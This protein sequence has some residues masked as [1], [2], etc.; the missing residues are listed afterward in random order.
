MTYGQPLRD[1]LQAPSLAG[2]VVLAGGAGLD[3]LVAGLNVMEVP[4]I[5]AYVKADELLLTT[6]F[7]LAALT[8]QA[9]EERERALVQLVRDLHA[10][11]LSGIAVKL[12]RYLDEIPRPVL[13]LAD[14]LGFPVVRLRH[15]VA[16]DDIFKEV[17]ASLSTLQAGVLER[18]DALHAALTAVVLEGGDLAHIAAEV[19]RVLDV[20]V[21]ITSTDGRERAAALAD[22][23]RQGLSAAELFDDTGRFRVERARVDPFG[24]GDGELR[25][26]PVIAGGSLLAR[27]VVHSPARRLTDADHQA[28]ERAAT[29]AALLITRQ[30]AVTAVERKY[31]GDFLREV[32]GGRGG[33]D[34]RIIEH[35]VGLGWDL[36]RP[37]VVVMG[38][39]DPP[40]HEESPVS[41]RVRRGWQERYAAA[42]RHV[43]EASDTSVAVADFSFEVVALVPVEVPEAPEQV[44]PATRRAVAP[45]VAAIRGDR[46]GGRRS[47]SVGVSRLVRRPSDLPQAYGHARRAVEV[48]R[49]INGTGSLTTFDSLGLHRLIS[50]VPDVEE[51]RSFAVEVLGPLVEDSATA[52]DL[53]ATLQ[54]LLDTNLNVA[55]A[56][57]VQHFHYNTVRYRVS[58]L[59]SMLGPFSSDP[60]LR[61]DLAVALQVWSMQGW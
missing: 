20:G 9:G 27:L 6:G 4:D 33:D 60:Y 52:T 5:Q 25:L 42:W 12:G 13:D 43:L 54:I 35:A 26:F 56:A 28:L 41:A 2:S 40:T 1:V 16:F 59:E 7:P 3:K 45:I 11:G 61:L 10:R 29:V 46:G 24:S 18:I 47:F 14:E 23:A 30:L 49:R 31:R 15:D 34:E 8:P 58:K 19:A 36:D 39:L 50:L 17:Y 21:L 38:E 57:R 48:G 55:E 22:G 44:H 32:F 53:R 37:L 51:L